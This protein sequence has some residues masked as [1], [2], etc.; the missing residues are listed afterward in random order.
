[1]ESDSLSSAIALAVSVVLFYLASL[2]SACIGSIRPDKSGF[3]QSRLTSP[4]ASTQYSRL[5][6]PGPANAVYLISVLSLAA[7]LIS[8]V[9]LAIAVYASSSS[10]VALAAIGVL[11][12]LGILNLLNKRIASWK[13]EQIALKISPVLRMLG[14]L[15]TP[16]LIVQDIV[17]RRISGKSS[18]GMEF[19]LSDA[20]N[21]EMNLPLESSNNILDEPEVRMI[22]AVVLLDQTTAK[23]I[24]IPRV[25]IVAAEIGT[26]IA[27]LAELMVTNGHSRIPVYSGDLDHIEGVCHARDILARLGQSGDLSRQRLDGLIR[28]AF[29]IPE[30]KNLEELLS[31]FQ[32]EHV[33]MAIVIN[34]YG[35]VSGLVTIEDLLE[36]I[37]GEIQ[38]EFDT[39][40]VEIEKL[41]ENEYVIDAGV[42]VDDLN[43][44]MNTSVESN[45]FETIGGFVYD[46]LGKIPSP[47]DGVTYD[48]LT[49]EVI[50][51][52]GRRLKK[53]K[54]R[55]STLSATEV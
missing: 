9:F 50:S 52:V 51:T 2:A 35:G 20:T 16:V 14:W 28:P 47:G 43:D 21:V 17:A 26:S 11:I 19:S 42:S 36:E 4:E 54:V 10:S 23:E 46:R 18:S 33:Q 39:G 29:F 41:D 22:R 30:S 45:G 15:L 13:G 1:M 31:E 48:G 37:V 8:G 5:V 12:I 6:S 27:E 40:D 53:L 25:D 44:L 32:H 24:M 3:L 38:D 55:K 49:I 7:S 34:E